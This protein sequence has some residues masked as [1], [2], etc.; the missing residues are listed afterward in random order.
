MTNHLFDVFF[1][2]ALWNWCQLWLPV[3]TFLFVT[4]IYWKA[5]SNQRLQNHVFCCARSYNH[6]EPPSGLQPCEMRLLQ[7]THR[8]VGV[9][10]AQR[11]FQWLCPEGNLFTI[12]LRCKQ[13]GDRWPCWSLFKCFYCV[14][15]RTCYNT[16]TP[17]AL[18]SHSFQ[19]YEVGIYMASASAK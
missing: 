6:L 7:M 13:K 14:S 18:L 3:D 4:T 9:Q 17:P 16:L 12:F 11:A 1:P 2:S 19:L 15:I 5:W 10:R 8:I